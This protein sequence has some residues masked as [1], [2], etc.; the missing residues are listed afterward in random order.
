MRPPEAT[1][2]KKTGRSGSQKRR[3]TARIAVNCTPAEK[4]IIVEKSKDAG[5]SPSAI[6]LARM[7]DAPMPKRRPSAL[8]RI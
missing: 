3:T 4:A 7:L 1:A 5:L 8:A 6:C 2:V